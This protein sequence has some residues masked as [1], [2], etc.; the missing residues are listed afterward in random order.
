MEIQRRERL[1]EIRS[2]EKNRRERARREGER[3]RE[4]RDV[5]KKGREREERMRERGRVSESDGG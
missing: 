4:D 2:E 3:V 1:R 5:E